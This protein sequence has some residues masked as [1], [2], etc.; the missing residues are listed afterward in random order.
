MIKNTGSFY[1]VED[2]ESRETVICRIRG[3]FRLKNSRNTNPVA[4]GDYVRYESD[5]AGSHLITGIE[6]RENYIIRRSTNLSRET[7]II[8]ANLDQAFVVVT[9]DFPATKLEFV[10]RFLVTAEA[11]KIPAKIILNKS[12]LYGPE[13][14][15]LLEEFRLT[16]R[17]AGYE[18]IETSV[19][20]G[21]NID[22]L[23]ELTRDRTTLLSGNSGVGKS[24]LIKAMDPT[25]DPK[26][27]EIS[28]YHNRGKHTTTFS[29]IYRLS[30]GGYLV[31]TPGIKGFGLV[32]FEKEEI[33]RYFPEL[34]R[35]SSQCRFYNCTHTHE[36]GCAVRGAVEQGEIGESRYYSYLKLLEDEG[37]KYR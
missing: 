25:L 31:D 2:S 36:P 11:Y 12:D 32:D 23:R 9:L 16:Y 4:V 3:N 29:E 21:T 26:T 30:Y 37:N 13:Y 33:H 19:T 15:P 22:Q 17:Q 10:D 34:F 27:G 7:H 5:G 20:Q 18:V 1:H 28:S 6:E 24:S 8:A 35:T 14:G